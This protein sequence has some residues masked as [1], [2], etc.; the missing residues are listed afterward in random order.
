MEELGGCDGANYVFVLSESSFE[1]TLDNAQT[2]FL[3]RDVLHGRA[4]R[5][6]RVVFDP[7]DTDVT[8]ALSMTARG[9]FLIIHSHKPFDVPQNRK[10]A[11]S[12]LPLCEH[13]ST[14]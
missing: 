13:V 7:N 12:S 11:F 8:S 10:I 4:S 14:E 9:F 3:A 1:P 6:A 2:S 5:S